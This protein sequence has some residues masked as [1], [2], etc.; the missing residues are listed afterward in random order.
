[1]KSFIRQ[2]PGSPARR[3]VRRFVAAMVVPALVMGVL[4]ASAPAASAAGVGSVG[5]VD[6]AIGF[7]TFFGDTTGLKMAPCLD[8][9]PMCTAT[10][11][12]LVAPDGE[13]FYSLSQATAGPFDLTL[14]VEGAF[15]N[16]LPDAFQRTRFNTPKPGLLQPG[17]VSDGLCKGCGPILRWEPR[18]GAGHD[19]IQWAGAGGDGRRRRTGGSGPGD[20]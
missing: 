19:H 6:P 11:A 4:A 14:A 7:P 17:G 3:G 8:G 15:L 5:P 20:G 9:L 2:V 12:E 10:A 13:M 18:E 16:G 1:M